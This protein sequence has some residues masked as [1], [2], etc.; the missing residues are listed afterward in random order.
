MSSLSDLPGEIKQKKFTKALTRLGFEIDTKGGD[1]SHVK[2]TWPTNQKMVTIPAFIPKQTLRYI[3]KEIEGYN[4][5]TWD[6][7]KQQL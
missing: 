2:A 7:I 4:G 1:G 5:I 3:L 6:Q